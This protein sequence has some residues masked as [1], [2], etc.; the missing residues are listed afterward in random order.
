MRPRA[1]AVA[2]ALLVPAALALAPACSNTDRLIVYSGRTSNLVLPILERF[3]EDTGIGIDVRY[4]DSADLALQIDEEG[5]RSPADVFISQ[6]P[7]AAGFLDAQGL[8]APLPDDLLELVDEA[9]R[10]GDG[11]WVGMSGRVRVLAY[12][13]DLVDPDDLP[14]SVLDLTDPAYAGQVGV[15]PENGSFQDFVTAMRDSIGDDEALEW[16]EG[17]ADNDSPTYA[18]NVAIVEAIGRGEIPFGLVNHYYAERALDEDPD[19][20][21][22]NH[23][24][25]DDDLG[26]TLLV[27]AAAVLESSDR[28]DDGHRLI[29]YL[30]DDESQ[31]YFADETF[32]YPLAAG[33][34]PSD[35]VPPLDEITFHRVDLDE[36]GGGLE[37]TTQLIEQ[38]GLRS[39]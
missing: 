34:E 36:L 15:A 39:G 6:S 28:S 9:A 8:L 20:P 12:N 18:N 4:G 5:D 14:A 30:L 3:S 38:S 10:A 19:L 27:T 31:R 11:N 33:V 7:G 35:A 17:M 22:A 26:S 29:E 13:T 32:E 16:L 25:G 24:F 37:A 2:F 23:F 21:V 1:R